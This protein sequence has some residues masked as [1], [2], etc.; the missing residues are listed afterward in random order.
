MAVKRYLAFALLVAGAVLP[1]CAQRGGARGGSSGRGAAS[2]ASHSGASF[3]GDANFS[4]F[5]G[6]SPASRY[7]SYP[8]TGRSAA[9]GTLS[10]PSGVR[11]ARPSF[12]SRRPEAPWRPGGPDRYRRPI[13]A[14]YGLGLAYA[15]PGWIAPDYLSYCDPDFDGCYGSEG[16]YGDQAYGDAGYYADP[17]YYGD[18]A[19]ASAREIPA[20]GD[21]AAGPPAAGPPAAGYAEPEQPMAAATAPELASEDAITLIFKDGRPPEQVHNY[22]LTRTTLYVI[23]GGRRRDIPVA[24]LDLAATIKANQN[25]GVDFQLP[26]TSNPAAP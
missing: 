18:E 21:P 26:Q 25:A 11:L 4:G 22:A 1:V 20:Y 23:N 19:A 16:Y 6:F 12:Y 8:A 15:Y 9:L 14:G 5:R 2:F 10:A 7:S 13:Y 3:R 24:D 17:G